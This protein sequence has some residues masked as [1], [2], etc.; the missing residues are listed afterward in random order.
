MIFINTNFFQRKKSI[1]N[2]TSYL[3]KKIIN[4]LLLICITAFITVFVVSCG[5]SLTCDDSTIKTKMLDELSKK[6][7]NRYGKNDFKIIKL[8]GIITITQKMDS[9]GCNA[10]LAAEIQGKIEAVRLQYGALKYGAT[11][12]PWVSY[13]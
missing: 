11:I 3:E 2:N 10:I 4:F 9:C 6:F 7:Q 5:T 12:H 13:Y 1:S 8:G